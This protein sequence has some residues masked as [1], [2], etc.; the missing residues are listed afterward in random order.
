M[1]RFRALGIFCK[2]VEAE[3]MTEAARALGVSKAV[4][5]KYIGGLEE[6]LGVRLFHRTTR[7][8]R[9]TATG[10]AVFARARAMLEQMQE[11]EAAAKAEKGEPVG[12]LRVSAPLGFGT[13]HLG[14]PLAAFARAH[15][16][17]HLE[18]SLSDR[19]VRLAD[20]GFDV[21]VR[22][23]AKLEDED[24]VAVRLATTRMIACAS[25]EYLKRAG[26]LRTPHD[27]VHHECIAF[28]SPASSGRVPWRF[29]EESTDGEAVWIDPVMRVDSSLLQRDLARAGLGVAFLLSF[30]AERELR[31][32]S[33]VR[34]LE[35]FA[36]E[37]RTVWGVYP[38]PQHA[39]AKVRA[40]VRSLQNAY[41]TA[42]WAE[43]VDDG[44]R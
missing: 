29:D 23:A 32:G 34:V 20:E 19:F 1:D 9:P 25:P 18:V 15:P 7:S 44:R 37:Q 5:S 28:A 8:V 42:S 21:A 6:D 13:L 2:V 36:T 4:V 17:V 41:R 38:S 14:G 24:V 16:A 43:R 35:G 3:G 30:V 27:L 40:F 10:R 31:A 11:L 26:R 12:T 39:S 22:I 33:L